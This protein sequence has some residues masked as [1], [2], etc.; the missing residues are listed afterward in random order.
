MESL[1]FEVNMLW[2]V[3]GTQAS[4]PWPCGDGPWPTKDVNKTGSAL[5]HDCFVRSD[6][7][8]YAQPKTTH[9]KPQI[10]FSMINSY[11]KY[12]QMH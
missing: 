9:L 3:G 12:L 5:D 8:V 4:H 7:L 11:E 6:H 1:K 10:E 2:F